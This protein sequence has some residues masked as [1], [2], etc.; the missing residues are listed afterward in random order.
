MQS[1]TRYNQME[2]TREAKL[3]QLERLLES[4][5]LH[6]SESLKAFLRFV[7]LKSLE[8][9]ENDLKEYTIAT[10]VFGRNKSYDSR[11]DSVVRVQASRLRGKLQDYYANEGKDD[12]VII[13][14]PKGHYAPVF[15]YASSRNGA[16]VSIDAQAS[17]QASEIKETGASRDRWWRW[18]IAAFAVLAIGIGILAFN[19][20]SEADRDVVTPASRKDKSAEILVA[21]P[22]W[23]DFLRSPEPVLVAFSNALFQGTAE[24]GMKTLKPM[25][26][27]GQESSS[28]QTAQQAG[29]SQDGDQ[30]ITEHYTGV[31]EVMGV[32]FLGDFFSKADHPFRVKRSLLLNWDDLKTDNIVILGSPAENFVLRELPQEQDFR[33][34][35]VRDENQRMTFGIINTKP[36]EGEQPVYLAKQEGPSRSQISEDYAIVSLLRGLDAEH[37]LMILA[38]I[39]TFGTQAA[40]EYV[41]RPEYVK[42]LINRLN[43]GS[44]DTPRLPSYYQVLIKIKVN[45]GV[46]VQISYVTHHAL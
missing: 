29:V 15:S 24:T 23:N 31:G 37:R 19:Y 4:R 35:P 9:Q 39:T 38:G 8:N 2:L 11:S 12:P 26:P 20:R 43:M 10:E 36:K 25:R 40:A 42:E 5:S 46:P 3:E 21:L 34:G 17:P 33:F 6:G 1:V 32:Y 22:L 14:L 13:D 30:T 44:A 7:V 16:T 45:G 28:P 18:A 27:S 41:T